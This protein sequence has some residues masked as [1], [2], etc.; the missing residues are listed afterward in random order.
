MNKLLKKAATFIIYGGVGL[1][2]LATPALASDIIISGNGDS[3]KNTAEVTVTTKTTITQGNT[4]DYTNTLRL[5]G[6]TGGNEAN[7]NTGGD[8]DISTGNVEN[9]ANVT[10]T[11]GGNTATINLAPPD[12]P[13]ISIEDNGS[14]TTNK[15]TVKWTDTT[16]AKQTNS[17]TK[18]NKV[19]ENGKTGKNKANKNTGGT[20]T[21]ST[22][23]VTNG[24]T[25]ENT[26]GDNSLT[27]EP[28]P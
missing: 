11:G 2:L 28:P 20:V 27:L 24:S 13:N 23:N 15:A 18:K 1:S 12:L 4:S 22:G 7:S 17:C 25:V 14:K 26:C 3:S 8:V 10:N 21:V 6:D 16:K 9:T 5:S 19:K